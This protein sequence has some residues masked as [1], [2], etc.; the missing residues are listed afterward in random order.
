MYTT[1]R[2]TC[3]YIRIPNPNL[4]M[5]KYVHRSRCIIKVYIYT[6]ECMTH[7]GDYFPCEYNNN[8]INNLLAIN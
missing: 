3:T 1:L 8:N 5:K 6:N 7:W 2:H 4:I